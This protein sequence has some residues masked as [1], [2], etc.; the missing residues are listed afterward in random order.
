M[1]RTNKKSQNHRSDARYDGEDDEVRYD[2]AGPEPDVHNDQ[3]EMAVQSV[4]QDVIS[5]KINTRT[6]YQHRRGREQIQVD[7]HKHVYIHTYIYVY[8]FI[9]VCIPIF[10][11]IYICKYT[12][13]HI[14]N[15]FLRRIN[16]L[17]DPHPT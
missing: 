6:R 3:Q 13:M 14:C 2:E 15:R 5:E 17:G 4:R 9:Y 7:I 11:N 16:P 10:M 1:R 12:L 8:I